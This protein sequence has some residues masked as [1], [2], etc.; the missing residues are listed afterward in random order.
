MQIFIFLSSV[1]FAF[2]CPICIRLLDEVANSSLS[3]SPNNDVADFIECSS[4]TSEGHFFL[5]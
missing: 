4:V 3:L 5:S 1:S 2:N